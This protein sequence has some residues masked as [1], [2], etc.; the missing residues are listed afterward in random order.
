[1]VHSDRG[2][3]FRSRRFVH[4]FERHHLLGSM[5]RVASSADNDPSASSRPSSLRT[6]TQPPTRREPP[7][8]EGQP[9]PQQSL[10]RTPGN[11]R[12]VSPRWNVRETC[13]TH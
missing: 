13:A 12:V 6:S 1:V 10:V 2:S 4:A 9:D 5:G 7:D 3:Q 11:A 8:H